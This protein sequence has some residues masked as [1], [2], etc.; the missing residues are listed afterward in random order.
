VLVKPGTLKLEGVVFAP[1]PPVH[2]ER[3][4]GT[5]GRQL[6]REARI[7]EAVTLTVRRWTPF[8]ITMHL[9][10]RCQYIWTQ[11]VYTSGLKMY[12]HLVSRWRT[13][14]LAQ[15]AAHQVAGK[16]GDGEVTQGQAFPAAPGE[17]VR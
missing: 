5:E 15:P 17:E 14:T 16:V 8:P 1:H 3:P 10:S 12:R 11:Y 2:E 4:K 7:S 13:V 6:L 9:G